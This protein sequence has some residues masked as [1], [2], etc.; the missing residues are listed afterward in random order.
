VLYSS[1]SLSG[2]TKQRP[3][4]RSIGVLHDKD[5]LPSLFDVDFRHV[6]VKCLAERWIANDQ[7][8]AHARSD[9]SQGRPVIHQLCNNVPI[10]NI[11]SYDSPEVSP[12]IDHK[13]ASHFHPLLNMAFDGC[14]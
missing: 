12:P 11:S 9:L 7:V 8:E 14:E 2:F 3:S 4:T 10:L 5:D 1:L 6:V 13:N